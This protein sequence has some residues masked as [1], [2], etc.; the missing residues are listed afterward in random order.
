M[1]KKRTTSRKREEIEDVIDTES[2]VLIEPGDVF[3]VSYG[4]GK[5]CS[6]IALSGTQQREIA[7]KFND[8]TRDESSGDP[9]RMLGSFEAIFELLKDVVSDYSEEIL[10]DIDRQMASQIVAGCLFKTAIGDDDRK[11]SV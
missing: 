11:K 3:E 5:H 7:R 2:T 8:I 6:V 4:N 9:E 10:D 1:A